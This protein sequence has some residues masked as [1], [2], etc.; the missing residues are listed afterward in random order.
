MYD[1]SYSELVT[2]ETYDDRLKYLQLHDNN[3]KSPRDR[4]QKFF[5]SKVWK[6]VRHDIIVRDRG[7]DLGVIRKDKGGQYIDGKIIVHHINPITIED[8]ENNSTKL[9]DPEN[10]ITTSGTT[11]NRIHYGRETEPYKDREPGDTILW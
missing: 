5:K 3:Y 4:S 2:L 10:L 8:I 1:R 9:L 7:F 6:K 11:H